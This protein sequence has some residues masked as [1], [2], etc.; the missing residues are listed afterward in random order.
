MMNR[1]ECRQTE[2]HEEHLR[3][4]G[5]CPWCG[6]VDRDKAGTMSDAEFV[7]LGGTLDSEVYG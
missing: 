2:G 4:N 3:M 5:E 6:E 7:A 1:A